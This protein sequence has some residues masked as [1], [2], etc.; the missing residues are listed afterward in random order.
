[1]RCRYLQNHNEVGFAEHRK[2]ETVQLDPG[3]AGVLLARGVVE[4]V[5]LTEA[6]IDA[7]VNAPQAGD[8]LRS[9]GEIADRKRQ[10]AIILREI[11]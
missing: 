5:P 6:E 4:H 2:G 11:N 10:Q 8:E 1:M 7:I 9:P 3:V